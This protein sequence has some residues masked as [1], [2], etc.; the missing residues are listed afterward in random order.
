[1]HLLNDFDRQYLLFSWRDCRVVLHVH[2]IDNMRNAMTPRSQ[3][4][5]EVTAGSTD[6]FDRRCVVGRRDEKRNKKRNECL[7]ISRGTCTKRFFGRIMNWFSEMNR[8]GVE[9]FRAGKCW[10][11]CRS[12]LGK[13]LVC[14]GFPVPGTK[15]KVINVDTPGREVSGP[16]GI[17]VQW[18]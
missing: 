14:S 11:D 18:L 4:L 16:K 3:S 10:W 6:G 17:C 1:M 13:T 5:Q 7:K 8:Q 15:V 12:S 9:Q 2:S